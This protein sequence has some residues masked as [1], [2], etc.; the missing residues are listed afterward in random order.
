LPRRRPRSRRWGEQLFIGASPYVSGLCYSIFRVEPYRDCPFGCVYCYRNW[1]SLSGGAR[2]VRDYERAVVEVDSLGLTPIPFRLSTLT[3]PFQPLEEERKLSLQVLRISLRHRYPLI[4]NTKSDLIGRDPWRALLIQLGEEGL[5]VVQISLSHVD[6]KLSDIE[7]GVPSPRR[8]LNVA[9]Y[10][11]ERDVPV[12]IRYQP[13]IPGLSDTEEALEKA[14]ELFSEAGVKH[15]V[16]EYLRTYEENLRFFES[17]A[18]D[19]DVYGEKWE[20]YGI[21]GEKGPLKPPL[22]YRR[23]KMAALREVLTKRGISFATCKEGFFDLHTAPDCCGMYLLRVKI[24]MRPTLAEAYRLVVSRGPLSLEEVRDEL[25][26][27]RGYASGSRVDVY[28][29]PLRKGLKW[30]ERV[31]FLIMQDDE[32]LTKVTPLL[33][34]KD[35][36]LILRRPLQPA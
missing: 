10:L 9:S 3:E 14:A 28:P 32:Q 18:R 36:K 34:F 13:L 25:T 1:Y 7:P 12:V 33:V 15:V 17:L 2:Q 31:L 26:H 29:R 22:K 21:R 5:V 35:G 4:I 6:E 27:M 23:A 8:L 24:L 11:A 20:Y 19:K 16:A 30:H